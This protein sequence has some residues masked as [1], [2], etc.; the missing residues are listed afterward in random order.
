[1]VLPKEKF[2]AGMLP[3]CAQWMCSGCTVDTQWMH[4]G[5]TVDASTA[6]VNGEGDRARSCY[7]LMCC[8]GPAMCCISTVNVSAASRDCHSNGALTADCADCTAALFIIRMDC[9]TH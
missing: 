5:C 8:S 4:S 6:N 1:M 9:S 3:R 7:A 2:T